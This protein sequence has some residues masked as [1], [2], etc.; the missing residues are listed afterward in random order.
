MLN[1]LKKL[2]KCLEDGLDERK[3]SEAEDTHRRALNYE[4]IEK[5][6]MSRQEKR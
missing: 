6:P 5:L 4:E 3:L 2:L 1:E